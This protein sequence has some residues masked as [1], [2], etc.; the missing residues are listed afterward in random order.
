MNPWEILNINATT[1]KKTIKR[2][3]AQIL[4][5]CNP[6]DNPEGFMQLRAAYEMAL[7][8]VGNNNEPTLYGFQIESSASTYHVEP[9]KKISEI[10]SDYFND[11]LADQENKANGDNQYSIYEENTLSEYLDE[12]A[13]YNELGLANKSFESQTLQRENW[14][15]EYQLLINLL[16][17]LLDNKALSSRT[18]LWR[19]LLSNP[20]VSKLYK[21]QFCVDLVDSIK[22]HLLKYSERNPLKPEVIALILDYLKTESHSGGLSDHDLMRLSEVRVITHDYLGFMQQKT[23]W[24]YWLNNFLWLLFSFKG[25]LCTLPYIVSMVIVFSSVYYIKGVP[26]RLYSTYLAMNSFCSTTMLV[27]GENQE[28]SIQTKLALPL[29]K[30]STF[31]S[32]TLEKEIAIKWTKRFTGYLIFWVLFALTAKRLHDAGK[33][34]ATMFVCLIPFI[35]VLILVWIVLFYFSDTDNQFGRSMENKAFTP[36]QYNR[37]VYLKFAF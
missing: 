22:S 4:K 18:D 16:Y 1:D 35:G 8:S 10:N 11:I 37:L 21:N 9:E 17:E 33:S 20:L 2:A 31:H 30:I 36:K 26:E 29:C 19:D 32:I 7:S 24:K 27:D 25:R 5:R 28:S 6:E 3:Y 23:R 12:L 15:N 14:R 13:N 34:A